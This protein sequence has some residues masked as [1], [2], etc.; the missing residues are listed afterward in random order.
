MSD[1]LKPYTPS[2]EMPWTL[3]RAVHLYRRIGM[4]ADY[5]TIKSALSS[6]PQQLVEDI[7]NQLTEGNLPERP[8]WADYTYDDYEDQNDHFEVREEFIIDFAKRMIESGIAEKWFLFW[9]NHFV[10]ELVV[11]ECNRYLWDYIKVIYQNLMGN[12]KVFVEE[13]GLTPAM[14][15]YLNGNQNVRQSPNEN[16]A[17]E[18]MELFTMGEGNNYTQNDVVNM[19][20]ALTGYRV[21]QYLC[22]MTTFEPYYCDDGPKTIFGQTDNFNFHSAHDLI[23]SHRQN[24]VANYICEKIYRN[25]VNNQV[26]KAVT[27]E[28]AQLFIDSNWS[29]APV[30]KA[31]FKSE[32]F[33]NEAFFCTLYSNPLELFNTWVKSAG[34]VSSEIEGS[35]WIY[36]WG[37]Y[38]LGMDLFNPINVA[39]WPGYRTWLNENSYTDRVKFLRQLTNQFYQESVADKL[40][41]LT[42]DLITIDN[43]PV[44]IT[45]QLCKYFLGKVPDEQMLESAVFNFKGDI[46]ANYYESGSWNINWGSAK[47]QIISL[48]MF[49]ITM[50]EKQL[51]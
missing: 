18:L 15:I 16:Y 4:G 41:E 44:H 7:V 9:H 34:I 13:I 22:E 10:T 24:E 39:G 42:L 29:L 49:M 51:I 11:Y 12:F 3:E 46:P 43:D 23:F 37:A 1:V 19:A 2:P 14:L 30:I 45:E 40:Y 17:R 21:R 36:R 25:F 38:D 33:F 32:H 27:A 47:D 50:P 6:D 48:C 8:Y 31:L 28:L 35:L 26:D 20:K 5:P